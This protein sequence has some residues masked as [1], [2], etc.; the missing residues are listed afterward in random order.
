VTPCIVVGTGPE[1]ELLCETLADAGFGA[2]EAIDRVDVARLGA[3][4]PAV[5][6]V[7]AERV[8]DDVLEALRMMRFVL[9]DATIG[10]YTSRYDRSW[11]AACHRA[12]ASCVLSKRSARLQIAAALRRAAAYG[13]YTDADF[14]QPPG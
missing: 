4:A 1:A 12:G 8:T 3:L 6:V 10:V 14:D 2:A 5:V 13:V 9:P 7:D 11:A